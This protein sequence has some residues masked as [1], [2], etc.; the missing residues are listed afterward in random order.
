MAKKYIVKNCPCIY[1]GWRTM[2]ECFYYHKPCID[3]TDCLIKQVIKKCRVVLEVFDK[4]KDDY[5][6][7]RCATAENILR[8]FEIEEV[9]ND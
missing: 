8:L 7:G 6:Q 9:N 3:C 2:Y 1:T 4:H 5:A